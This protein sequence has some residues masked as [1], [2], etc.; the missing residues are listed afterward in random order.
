MSTKAAASVIAEATKRGLETVRLSFAD[1]HGVLRGKT[2]PVSGLEGAFRRGVAMTSTLVLKD[3]SHRTVFPVWEADAGFGAGALTGAGDIIMRPDPATFRVLPWSPAS[4]WMLCDLE[5]PDG[6]PFAFGSR[7]VLRQAAARLADRGLDFVCGLELE[8]HVFRITAPNLGHAQGGM[9]GT[10]PDTELLTHGGQYL[11]EDRYDALEPV[12]EAIR[13]AATGLGL[14]VRS[15]EVEFGASQF[16][17]TFDPAGPLEQADAM[18]LFRAAVK[19]VCRRM[20]LHATFM[21]R[22]KVEH[23]MASG[24][25]LHQSLTGRDDGA[26]RF[27]P[28]PDGAPTEICRQWI[29]G[30]LEHA[31]A[32]CLLAAPTV[33]GYK[34]YQAFQLAPDRVA[35][36]RD[37]KGALLRTL[38]APGDTASRVENR[39]A[40]PAANPYFHIAGQILAGLDGLERGLEPPPA[41]DTP[42]AVAAPLLPRDLGTAISAF[43]ASTFFQSAL[44]PGFTDWLVRIK[45]AEWNRYLA[46][47]SDWEQREYFTLF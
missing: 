25:H 42:Y 22:P 41:A 20:G 44:Q 1:Q 39:L 4:G 15:M 31:V 2:L 46:T 26:N 5:M 13:K 29:A 35:W 24:W 28:G 33:N 7:Q 23:G 14:P 30:L 43:A 10:P 27:T 32:G 18:V 17:F 38:L 36:G 45:R 16:E 9:P 40:E 34:R 8:F 12:M 11:T 3:T 19:Q 6:S 21:S 47:V 37:N